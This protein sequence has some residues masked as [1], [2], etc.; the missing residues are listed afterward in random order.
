MG[1]NFKI[2]IPPLRL[3]APIRIPPLPPIKLQPL[4]IPPI[5]EVIKQIPLI[6]KPLTIAPI[7]V[8]VKIDINIAGL[9]P[10]HIRDPVIKVPPLQIPKPPTVPKPVIDYNA[11][12]M[13]TGL[14]VG[15]LE[16]I[17]ITKPFVMAGMAI[18]DT[19]SK[20]KASEFINNGNKVNGTFAMLPG[21]LLVQQIAND[22]SHGKSGD[23]LNKYVPDPKK[24][25]TSDG[26][27]IG[28]TLATDPKN[29]LNTVKSVATSNVNT[30]KNNELVKVVAKPTIIEIA[31]VISLPKQTI[32]SVPSLV[33]KIEAPIK[34]TI[35]EIA[36]VVS[37]PKP[38]VVLPPVVQAIKSTLAPVVPVL[39][40]STLA[41]VV[42]VPVKSTLAPVVPVPVKST[43]APVIT[44]PPVVTAIKSTLAPVITTPSVVPVQVQVPTIPPVVPIST[45][46]IAPTMTLEKTPVAE[47]SGAVVG[48]VVLAILASFL[49]L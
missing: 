6:S 44:T 29:T 28:K 40:K 43:L 49:L 25:I 39:V 34:P 47:N 41:P 46:P 48:G 36:K 18:A 31:K 32:V 13:A 19:A 21:G 38:A 15:V 20:G 37:L 14:I 9:P 2:N 23:T 17:P 35:M 1:L 30:I 42:P 10:V 16:T 3:P 12:K 33:K 4:H 11:L 22:A 26:I 27:A 8:P 24:M 5:K 45:L 7:K